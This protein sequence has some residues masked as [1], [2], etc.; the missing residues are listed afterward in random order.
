MR[1]FFNLGDGS[2][3]HFMEDTWL[4]LTPLAQEYPTLYNIAQQKH[5]SVAHVLSLVP[6][7][8]GFT[9]QLT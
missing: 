3:L 4:E 2:G 8:I 7:N 1:L 6:I 9:Q 5:V